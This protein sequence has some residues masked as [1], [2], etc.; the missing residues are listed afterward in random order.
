MGRVVM[1]LKDEQEPPGTYGEKINIDA[2]AAGIYFFTANING[3]FQTIK[4]I[5]I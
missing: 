2:L 5:K 1:L 4:F 3:Q